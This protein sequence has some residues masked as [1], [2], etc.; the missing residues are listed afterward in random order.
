MLFPEVEIPLMCRLRHGAVILLCLLTL[1]S[2]RSAV[3][4]E[5]RLPP[6]PP[7]GDIDTSL[8][9]T[10]QAQDILAANTQPD[11]LR[12]SENTRFI[13]FPPASAGAIAMLLA[14]GA[15]RAY[16]RWRRPY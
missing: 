8:W 10:P 9:A 6:P 12:P 2:V 15:V 4:T 7:L 16:K 3:A 1:I 11:A 5:E 14:L 13:P